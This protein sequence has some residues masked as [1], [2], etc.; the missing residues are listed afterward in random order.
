MILRQMKQKHYDL[1][2]KELKEKA[3]S[4]PLD[5][6]YTA[7]LNVDNAQYT[8]RLQP[9]KNR[10]VA[11]LQ[12]VQMVEGENGPQYVL[13]TGGAVLISLLELLIYQGIAE[14]VTE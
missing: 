6:S 9:E 8:V 10:K 5:A 3:F 13:I 2:C 7:T 12:A 11:I 4:A 1:F 14:K